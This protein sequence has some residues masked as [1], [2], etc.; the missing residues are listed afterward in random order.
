MGLHKC[1]SG[2][3]AHIGARVTMRLTLYNALL[4]IDTALNLIPSYLQQYTAFQ[5]SHSRQCATGNPVPANLATFKELRLSTSGPAK[6]LNIDRIQPDFKLILRQYKFCSNLVF[7]S[8]YLT[9]SLAKLLKF[10]DF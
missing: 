6:S 3:W 5:F 1:V 4:K 2:V 10:D 8:Q 9:L 7:S